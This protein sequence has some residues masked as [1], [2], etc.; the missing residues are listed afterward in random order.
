M[1]EP[2][3][4]DHAALSEAA[5]RLHA[6]NAREIAVKEFCGTGRYLI[7]DSELRESYGQWV[8]EVS[9]SHHWPLEEVHRALGGAQRRSDAAS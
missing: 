3:M 4:A 2:S 8:G 6:D 5:R 9:A 1:T 7:E